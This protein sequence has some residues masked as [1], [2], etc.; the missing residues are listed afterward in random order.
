MANIIYM[1]ING[2]RQGLISAGCSTF[3]S[4]GNR[5]QIGHEDEIFTLA[6]RHTITRD[7]NVKH[8]P[9]EIIKLVDKSS[10]LLGVSIS[11]NEIQECIIDFYRSSAEGVLKNI[12]Q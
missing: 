8:N 10:P 12:I 6:V 5:Y 7:Q 2:K 3:N 4:I 1:T 9:V 11:E